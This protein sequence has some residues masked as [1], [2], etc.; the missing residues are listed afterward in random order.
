MVAAHRAS[1]STA[2]LIDLVGSIGLALR[3]VDR[4]IAGGVDQHFRTL[5]PNDLQQ[6]VDVLQVDIRPRKSHDVT[7]R[8][9]RALQAPSRPDRSG[10]KPTASCVVLRHPFTICAAA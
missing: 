2:A 1:A 7:E 6:R 8:G 5:P 9:E 3:L 4:G 10:P